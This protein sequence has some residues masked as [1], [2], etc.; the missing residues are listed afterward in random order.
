MQITGEDVVNRLIVYLHAASSEYRSVVL[1]RRLAINN[2]SR[3]WIHR[4][5]PERSL[6]TLRLIFGVGIDKPIRNAASCKV[7]P[8]L[9]VGSR[10]SSQEHVLIELLHRRGRAT[11]IVPGNIHNR[12]GKRIGS[13]ELVN[14]QCV[15]DDGVVGYVS[16]NLFDSIKNRL[17]ASQIPFKVFDVH[18][19]GRMIRLDFRQR[20]Q[21]VGF[22][23][24][25]ILREQLASA[26]HFARS[27]VLPQATHNIG[28]Q[29]HKH[30]SFL[31]VFVIGMRILLLMCRLSITFCH[32]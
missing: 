17:I 32:Y 15:V 21:N 14:L 19:I 1:P 28:F 7:T 13:P 5:C 18:P 25:V 6:I 4:A 3:F 26:K 23:N 10:L 2:E 24:P 16:A 20:I 8:Q 29:V 27:V 31:L 30:P 11:L 9:T 12:L 22:I